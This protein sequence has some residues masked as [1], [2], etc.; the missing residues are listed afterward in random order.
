MERCGGFVRFTP[1][2]MMIANAV[3]AELV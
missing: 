1:R 2:G 3:L